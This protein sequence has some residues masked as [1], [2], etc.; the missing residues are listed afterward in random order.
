MIQEDVASV[1][2]LVPAEADLDGDIADVVLRERSDGSDLLER[3][4]LAGRQLAC[5][6]AELRRDDSPVGRQRRIPRGHVVPGSMGLPGHLLARRDEVHAQSRGN[7]VVG[8][9]MRLLFQRGDVAHLPDR[10]VARS[11]RGHAGTVEPFLVVSPPVGQ[12]E[13]VTGG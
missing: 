8:G 3:R 12:D 2:R 4:G 10:S 5:L 11:Y 9:A 7:D 6:D 13:R 1:V